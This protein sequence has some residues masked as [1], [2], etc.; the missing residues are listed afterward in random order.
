MKTKLY[1]LIFFIA[2]MLTACSGNQ[3]PG[4]HTHDVVGA[5][6]N[7]HSDHDH[8]VTSVDTTLYAGDFELF[9]EYPALIAGQLST[10]AVHF[11]R[12]SSYQPVAEGRLTVSLICGD[13]GIRHQVDKPSVPGIFRPALQPVVTGSCR[14][15]FNLESPSGNV[16]FTIPETMVYAS[17]EE[18]K[19]AAKAGASGEITFLKEQAWKTEFAT[20]KVDLSPFYSVIRT[21]ARVSGQPQSMVVLSA[22]AEG[23]VWLMALP[24]QTV[25]KGEVVAVI[26]SSGIENSL[27]SRLAELKLAYEKSKADY[28]RS[29]SLAES[30]TV[31]KKDF[32]QTATLYRQDSMRY[33]QLANQLTQQG[34][35]IM[36]PMDGFIVST[37]V[38]NGQFVDKTQSI[39]H[40]GN[41]NHLL[42]EAY[43]N[44]SDLEQVSGIF[45]ATFSKGGEQEPFSL[46]GLNGKIVSIN[47]YLPENTTRIPIVFAVENNGRLMP[48]MFLEAY[49]KTG[50]KEQAMV[51]PLSAI[52][53]EQGNYYVYV[54]KGG[55]KFEKR[56]LMTAH[57]DGI[58]TEVISG[59]AVGERI[60]TKGAYQVKL[61]AMAGE[62]PLHGHTH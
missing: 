52:M 28:E 45:D 33:Y 25:R 21:A 11:T 10:F 29:A 38:S 40:I 51:I 48:G 1:P 58:Y 41:K 55:E 7:D 5:S 62:L 46:A 54:Q 42:I 16:R 14:L 39:M 53:E 4:G 30:Q 56:Q 23:K 50:K 22:Q 32:L 57:S 44:Q 3:Q 6:A 26:Q 24:G 19:L 20:Q 43:V 13:K 18:A 34:F 60:V 27:E 2:A 49:L 36:S 37:Q 47:T 15:I 17:A 31:S 9:V 59:L 12:L 8:A 61:A 35:K